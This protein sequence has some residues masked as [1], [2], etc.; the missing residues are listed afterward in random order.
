MEK[1]KRWEEKDIREAGAFGVTGQA[2]EP[3]SAMAQVLLPDLV[4]AEDLVP[5]GKL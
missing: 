3:S 2:T 4:R 5:L 1:K